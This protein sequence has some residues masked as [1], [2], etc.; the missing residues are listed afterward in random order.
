MLTSF[1]ET[2]GPKE[3]DRFQIC[4]KVEWAWEFISRDDKCLWS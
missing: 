2:W 1:I 3:G 4:L